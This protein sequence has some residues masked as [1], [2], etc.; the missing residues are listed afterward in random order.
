MALLDLFR[1][2]P[3]WEHPDVT[4]RSNAVRR[5]GADRVDL[6]TS[7]ARQD[8]D[9]S[10]RLIALRKLSDADV[11]AQVAR[12]DA[13][14][15][16][17]DE[18]AEMLVTAA[19]QDKEG[20]VAQVAMAALTE[21]R[22]LAA[23]AKGARLEAVGR[24]A[25]SLLT[26]AR[27]LAS[28]ARNAEFPSLRAEAVERIDEA[29]LLADL[30]LRCEHKEVAVAAAERITDRETILSISER[31]KCK[32]ASRRAAAIL[33]DLAASETPA[34]EPAVAETEVAT[35]SPAP[36]LP[37]PPVEPPVTPPAAPDH[38]H[39]IALRES[40][41]QTVES[42]DGD[43]A[44]QGLE[45]ARGLWAQ[46]SALAGAEGEELERRFVRACEAC[47]KR[48]ES[49]AAAAERQA[50]A[51]AIC[52]GAAQAVEMAELEEARRQWAGIQRKFA[53]LG[54]GVDAALQAR[55]DQAAARL[56]AREAEEQERL[57]QA[58]RE[59][60]AQRQD[61]A[62]R[63]DALA[64]SEALSLKDADRCLREAKA[65]A[66][67][68]G[69]LPS[70]QD[71]D[72]LLGR[73]DHIRKVVHPR[74]QQLRE[75]ENWKRWANL[76]IQE[77]LCKRTEA[78]REKEDLEQIAQELREIDRLWKE[79][80]QVPKEEGDVLWARFQ[81]VRNE[82]RARLDEHFA[83]K[84]AEQTRNMELKVALCERAEALADS[85]DWIR[86]ADALKQL[87]A[88]WKTIGPVPQKDAK[89]IW[90][91]FRR[92]CD[93]FFERRKVDRRQRSETWA[94]NLKHKEKLCEQAEALADSSEW[95]KTAGEFKRL[96]AEW[97]TVGPVRK[98]HSDAIWARFRQSCDRFFDRYKHRGD[99]ELAARSESFA[100]TCA[101]LEGL[102]PGPDSAQ[103]LEPPADLVERVRGAVAHWHQLD[104]PLQTDDWAQRL[105]ELVARLSR[106]HPGV[107]DG[108]DLTPEGAQRRMEKLCARVE[109]IVSSVEP[110]SSS[111]ED[112]AAFAE[113]LRNALA[114]NTLGVGGSREGRWQAARKDVEAAQMTWKRLMPLHTEASNALRERFYKACNR[115]FELRPAAPPRRPPRHDTGTR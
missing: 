101:E 34:P 51:E 100:K 77:D 82:L 96:Q 62:A 108:T 23:V 91:R 85:T 9:A 31:A 60:L 14:Q 11:I 115:F 84:L 112:G 73:F 50:R 20:A 37:I 76:G 106:A 94:E 110:I 13:D 18:A 32:A 26:D 38:T 46:L 69:P 87:Q 5:L 54:K 80:S 90:E 33:A 28:I 71:R 15:E 72:A 79:S 89:V 86:T 105:T 75:D 6:L 56:Q 47:R 114:D 1:S 65:A 30:A 95:E 74:L 102:I 70:Q 48:I 104:R 2:K 19:K 12:S 61:L 67:N 41:C 63:L 81:S 78:L 53:E 58:A 68:L 111:A 93:R 83:R 44:M 64:S 36:A 39:D 35:A 42:L 45:D 8:K 109:S 24:A 3:E 29:E 4:I 16:V 43:R 57:A 17:R 52:N 99:L 92:A 27:V 22:H 40:L 88:E 21:P 55:F 10:V 7:I 59:N 103:K 98:K 25:L 107:L 113:R 66:D 49:R 97:K